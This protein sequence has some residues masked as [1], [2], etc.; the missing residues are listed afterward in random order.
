MPTY[1]APYPVK[2]KA[3]VGFLVGARTAGARDRGSV[4]PLRFS[5]SMGFFCPPT[6]VKIRHDIADRLAASLYASLSVLALL[7]TM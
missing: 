7:P 5:L 6:T 4:S 2:T 1:C 3:M